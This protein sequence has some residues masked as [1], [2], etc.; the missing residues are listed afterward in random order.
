MGKRKGMVRFQLPRVS[1]RGS[2]EGGGSGPGGLPPPVG[3]QR[4][5]LNHPYDNRLSREI[6]SVYGGYPGGYPPMYPDQPPPYS[7]NPRRLESLMH[8]WGRGSA[9]FPSLPGQP[10]RLPSDA[11][12]PNADPI[13]DYIH[14]RENQVGSPPGYITMGPEGPR[15]K[16]RDLHSAP[17]R[18]ST[19]HSILPPPLYNQFHRG[20]WRLDRSLR[21]G[22]RATS[23]LPQ[24]QEYWGLEA[25]GARRGPVRRARSLGSREGLVRPGP[26][27]RPRSLGSR[28]SY[29]PP[30]PARPVAAPGERSLL[31]RGRAGPPPGGRSSDPGF[32]LRSWL[33][34]LSS[35]PPSYDSNA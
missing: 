13:A 34:R 4:P 22:S 7:S 24:H 32:F 29:S 12:R 8:R 18:R 6:P 10:P 31:R 27:R 28:E 21:P 33:N 9:S 35:L 23:S 30:L 5:W 26:A 15:P 3:A 14:M 25:P 1:P 20:R 2:R 19:V 17:R 11:W 16:S